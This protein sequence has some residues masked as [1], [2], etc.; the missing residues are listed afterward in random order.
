[1]EF[2]NETLSASVEV[3]EE[4]NVVLGILGALVGAVLGGASIILLS[5]LGY[6][7]SISGVILA[8]C[9]LKGYELLAKGLST[10]GIVI[11]VILMLVT[12]FAADLLDWGIAVYSQLGDYGYSFTECMLMLPEFFA[13]GTITMGEYLKNLGM[14]YLFVAIGGFYILKGAFQKK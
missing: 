9:T 11:C 13:D 6:V 8:F 4:E 10:K 12:P 3:K 2:E 5:Q 14:I 7:A 1:M